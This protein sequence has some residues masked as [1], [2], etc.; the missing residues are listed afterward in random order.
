M[1]LYEPVTYT[2][3]RDTRQTEQPVH[4]DTE[5]SR[6]LTDLELER[7]VINVEVAGLPGIAHP[8]TTV[9]CDDLAVPPSELFSD[10]LVG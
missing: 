5:Q 2:D 3:W 1:C 7:T 9:L 10:G 6:R 4:R 8:L